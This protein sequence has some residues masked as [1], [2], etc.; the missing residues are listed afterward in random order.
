MRAEW[1]AEDLDETTNTYICRS[2]VCHGDENVSARPAR[3]C[4]PDR[5][6]GQRGP[7]RLELQQLPW[8]QRTLRAV[9]GRGRGQQLVD[10][11]EGLPRGL[12][13][14]RRRPIASPDLAH[15]PSPDLAHQSNRELASFTSTPS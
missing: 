15:Q 7:H 12:E 1:A 14:I 6:V 13:V 8:Q 5:R 9:L 4:A 10:A 2:L 11:R 3:R